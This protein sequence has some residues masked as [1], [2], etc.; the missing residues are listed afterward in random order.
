[1]IDDDIKK[2]SLISLKHITRVVSI[3]ELCEIC[4]FLSNKSKKSDVNIKFTQFGSKIL[5]RRGLFFN[6]VPSIYE[7]I[8]F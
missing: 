5:S 7:R 8:P 1:M 2:V 4:D 6:E 3:K